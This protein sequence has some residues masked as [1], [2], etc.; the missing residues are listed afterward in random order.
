[1]SL[2]DAPDTVAGAF[3][4]CVDAEGINFRLVEI[5]ANLRSRI[6]RLP[7]GDQAMF[8]SR[9]MFDRVGGFPELAQMEDYVLIRR[10]HKMERIRTSC[11]A[12]RTSAR[13]WQKHGV[14]RTTLLH[15]TMIAA[16]HLGI[17]PERIAGWRR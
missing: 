8:I 13:R 16:Y 4:L 12:V 7:Y 9:Q 6:R 5:G 15:Q 2:L 11:D 14:W 3:R 1:M 10:L 17:S